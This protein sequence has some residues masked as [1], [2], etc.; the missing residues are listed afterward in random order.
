[1]GDCHMLS[2]RGFDR[3][4][5]I[6]R[7][8]HRATRRLNSESSGRPGASDPAG[9]HPERIRESRQPQLRHTHG[10]GSSALEHAAKAHTAPA[11][12]RRM[13]RGTRCQPS[14]SR[15]PVQYPAGNR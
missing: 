15:T 2:P 4:E 5:D 11:R 14:A 9:I 8:T 6:T 10:G 7:T 13:T 12:G 3:S 1:M